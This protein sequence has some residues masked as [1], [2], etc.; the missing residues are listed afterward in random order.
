MNIILHT[1]GSV[2]DSVDFGKSHVVITW[3]KA[4]GEVYCHHATL[5]IAFFSDTLF[6]PYIVRV[7]VRSRNNMIEKG[8]IANSSEKQVAYYLPCT[9]KQDMM[10]V[11]LNSTQIIDNLSLDSW[12]TLKDGSRGAHKE[13]PLS[14]FYRFDDSSDDINHLFKHEE[15]LT[16]FLLSE[17]YFN[18]LKDGEQV[19]VTIV[20]D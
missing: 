17:K 19:D 6:T 15:N 16:P 5:F 18:R 7:G 11:P 13:Y 12:S 1:D 8:V 14:L 4:F 9:Y 3:A 20:F 2:S 10:I